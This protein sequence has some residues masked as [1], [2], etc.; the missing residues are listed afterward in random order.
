MIAAEP[1]GRKR[2]RKKVAA[3]RKKRKAA[4]A[5]AEEAVKIAKKIK[6]SAIYDLRAV[7]PHKK[8]EVDTR[9]PKRLL[10]IIERKNRE[11]AKLLAGG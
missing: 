6:T 4:A 11:I 1:A 8:A 9:T 2:D 3:L 5:K 10:G 7:N